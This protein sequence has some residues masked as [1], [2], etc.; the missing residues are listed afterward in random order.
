MKK[1]T[2]SILVR[3][4]KEICV[5]ME[6]VCISAQVNYNLTIYDIY[7]PK[8]I[9]NANPYEIGEVQISFPDAFD[10]INELL[11]PSTDI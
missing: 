2:A 8:K 10:N 7:L 6:N 9:T 1:D 4:I 3:K 11:K 5:S